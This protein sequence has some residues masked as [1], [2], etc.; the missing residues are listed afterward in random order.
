MA[1]LPPPLVDF[2]APLTWFTLQ[3]GSGNLLKTLTTITAGGTSHVP[4]SSTTYNDIY[5]DVASAVTLV[6]PIL[7]NLFEG[8]EWLVK[9]TMGLASTNPITIQ[10]GDAYLID[11]ASSK[12][13]NTNFGYISL[14]WDGIGMRVKT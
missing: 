9:D 14:V 5:V 6:L 4:G 1:D 3:E 2:V 8:Q 11:G 10:P 13:V 12:V 7:S